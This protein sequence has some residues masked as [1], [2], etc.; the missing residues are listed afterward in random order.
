[1]QSSK[2]N[3]HKAIQFSDGAFTAVIREDPGIGWPRDGI[4]F[5]RKVKKIERNYTCRYSIN[6]AI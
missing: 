4:H 2:I 3:Y 1:M 6:V 5:R